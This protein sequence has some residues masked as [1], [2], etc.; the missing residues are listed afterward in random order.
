MVEVDEPCTEKATVPGLIQGACCFCY[1]PGFLLSLLLF[2]WLGLRRGK[3][4]KGEELHRRVVGKLNS[5]LCVRQ[6]SHRSK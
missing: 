4:G 1:S 5:F 2:R 3:K 6:K